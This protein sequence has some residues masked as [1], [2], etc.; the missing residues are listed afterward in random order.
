M[1][2]TITTTLC[3][4]AG[5][6]ALSLATVGPVRA[7]L[8]EWTSTG[9]G[10][11]VNTLTADDS[12]FYAGSSAGLYFSENAGESWQ[13][14]AEPLID[15]NILSLTVRPDG[16]QLFAG[17]HLG[18]QVSIDYGATWTAIGA[19][20]PGVMA[21][22][23]GPSGTSYVYAGTFGRGVFVSADSGAT[24]SASDDLMNAIVYALATSTVDAAT[25][26]AGTSKGLYL[27]TDSGTRWTLVEDLGDGV[28]VRAILPVEERIVVGTYGDGVW[29]SEDA[30]ATWRNISTGL[31]PMQVRSLAIDPGN[32]DIMYAATSTGGFYRTQNSGTQWLAVNAGL[33]QFTGR[34]VF[35]DPADRTRLLGAGTGDGVW[36]IEFGAEA[37]I[38]VSPE[39]FD[40]GSVPVQTAVTSVLE[41]ANTGTADLEIS[42][43]RMG[44]S[45]GF[46]VILSE[47]Q[48]LPITV[49]NQTSSFV[50]VEF[51]PTVRDI[52]LRDEV[53][54]TSSDQNER[55]V[56]ISVTGR[57]TRSVLSP[58]RAQVD[59]GSVR[60]PAFVDT[61]IVLTNTGSAALELFSASFD[62]ARFRVTGFTPVTLLPGTST[63]IEF[64]FAP[65]TPGAEIGNLTIVSDSAPSMLLVPV[66]GAGTA[67][68]INASESILDFGRVDLGQQ[69]TLPL[70]VT[71]TGTADL[72][73]A[74][75]AP[76]SG[77]FSV[78]RTLGVARDTSFVV[79]ATDTILVASGADTTLQLPSD[80]STMVRVT[81]DTTFL[82]TGG[83]T[84][85]V[86]TVGADMLILV[87]TE[88][89]VFFASEDSMVLAPN[90]S[91]TLQVTYQPTVSGHRNDTL[92]IVSD[93]PL[94]LGL[95]RVLLRGEGNALSLEPGD[96][97]PV[98]EHPVQLTVVDLDDVAGP[99]LAVV[100]SV[101]GQLHVLL[102]DGAGDFGA[103]GQTQY[104]GEVASYSPWVAPV[105]ITAAPVFTPTGRP[106][107]IVGDR[108]MRSISI[109]QNDGRGRFGGRRDD[110]FIGHALGDLVAVDLDAD[111]DTDIAVANGMFSDSITLL[112]NDGVGNFSARALLVVGSGLPGPVAIAAAHFDPDGYT[113]L[114]VA[115]RSA[116]TVTVVHNDRNGS[117]TFDGADVYAVGGNPLDISVGDH[118]AD[119]DQDIAVAAADSRLISILR[120]DGQAG[121]TASASVAA[122]QR[123]YA[124]AHGGLTADIFDDLVIGGNG[125]F[126]VFLKNEGGEAFED[127]QVEVGF[128]VRAVG[129]A[130]FDANQVGDIVVLSADS[131]RVRLFRNRLVGRLVPPRPPVA[132]VA[133]DVSGDL[134]G[135]IRI[136]WE[137][138]DYGTRGTDEQIIR[139]TSYAVWRSNTAD[140]ADAEFLTT[141][142][143][144]MRTFE[145]ETATPYQSFYYQVTA[146]RADLT[147]GP[148]QTA[149]A[150]SLPAPL[151]DLKL[152]NAPRVSRGDTFEV[153]LFLT[154]AQ[155]TVAGVSLFLT[156]EPTALQLLPDPADTTKPFRIDSG[157]LGSFTPV[158]NSR[159]NAV[160]GSGLLDLSLIGASPGSSSP[161]AAGVEPVLLGSLWFVASQN[162]STFI[163]IDDDFASNRRTAVVEDQT[164]AW[165]QP[166]IGDTTRLTVRDVFVSGQ[167]RLQGLSKG[168]ELSSSQATLLFIGAG[169]DTLVS[170]L[171]DED[172]FKPGIQVTL[173]TQ[174][175]FF[176]DQIPSSTYRVF[177]KVPTHLQGSVTGDTVTVD[178]SRA[179]LTF[180]WVAPDSTSLDTLPAGDA[181]DDNRVNL[182]DFGVIVRHYGA[183]SA[184]GE[185]MV[186]QSADFD[187]DDRIAHS[188][189]MLLA[190]NFGRVGMEISQSAKAASPN[191]GWI[192][193][194]EQ[195]RLYGRDLGP[196]RGIS[197]RSK[198][199]SFT[200]TTEGTVFAGQSVGIRNW[201]TVEGAEH[202]AL[203]LLGPGSVDGDGVLLRLGSGSDVDLGSVTILTEDGQVV[204]PA[205]D[206]AFLPKATVLQANYP[207]PFNPSTQ[208]PFT[209]GARG[210]EK[211]AVRLEIYDVL[212][213]RIRML[214]DEAMLPGQ[215][216]VEWDSRDD[217]GAAVASGMYFYQ[218]QAGE[219]GQSK[220]LMLLR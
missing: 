210:T 204:R 111:G 117:F 45:A 15:H 122:S 159:H 92:D 137:D 73:I 54:I 162:A 116:N 38:S 125:D 49:P 32:P 109:V 114:A 138:G 36:E 171:N 23:L 104:P 66:T 131:A 213:Q 8:N 200:P 133:E 20:G 24:W 157:I 40:F 110:I 80:D 139:T 119:G 84:T 219:V 143:G 113:D 11:V 14:L 17:S 39:S 5:T 192:R 196:L 203:A 177:T 180:R 161:L 97:I 154:S 151:V 209:I 175:R 22:A 214:V 16:S 166:V 29:I 33:D 69:V 25:V 206:A 6:C 81:A 115:N 76:R 126:L 127:Q 71:N 208:I 37:K 141:L 187:G 43:V 30:G 124:L 136:S 170:T 42:S 198:G 199:P 164:G 56:A 58:S 57:G 64:S 144:G 121:F 12:R 72:T 191:R 79:S 53:R 89:T 86:T 142:P 193:L 52:L 9:I 134:G 35:T 135:S 173:D 87:G 146:S 152:A 78:D 7:D 176:L 21:I 140:F 90:A 107:I 55:E 74:R 99:D 28:S 88:R 112:Y 27:S 65:L 26:Y 85:T 195:G 4:A 215:Y 149:T 96:V 68:D 77:E 184:G 163:A 103:A 185:W 174:G 10:N 155:T 123:P 181:N 128:P 63:S 167:L 145:D 129:V 132:V 67:P 46:S 158:V 220:S 44:G 2:T 62:N 194:D 153:Q 150:Q 94:V 60:L 148:S 130:D 18:L 31:S 190:D 34:F 101:S 217:A 100:D 19:P 165:I 216:R 178:S 179:N 120:N 212:G 118:D 91:I 183:T 211:V 48:T 105:A 59:F 202:L 98:G 182:A 156:Y 169:N 3:A 1:R 93:A 172:R 70:E 207:N 95:L 41:I 106:D 201:S 50:E 186:A 108:V 168:S 218:L 47:S 83:D 61:T 75:L 147:S 205:P 160:A 197:L 102:N 82:I 51:R 13:R 188:D 189:F